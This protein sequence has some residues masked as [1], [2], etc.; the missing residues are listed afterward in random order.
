MNRESTAFAE[1]S[2]PETAS[3]G[4]TAPRRSAVAGRV[5]RGIEGGALA[6]LVMTVYRLPVTRS[7]PPSAEFWTTFVAGGR[8]G[9]HP[10][11]ALVLHF[12]Y[13]LGAGGLFAALISDRASLDRERTRS[14]LDDSVSGPPDRSDEVTATMAGLLYGVALSAV[15]ERFVLGRLLGTEPD[16]RFA[17]HVGHVLYGITLG[18]WVGTR[19]RRE[20]GK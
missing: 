20:K 3:D 19:T 17:F 10:L 13:G 15:G 4:A 16:D 14:F 6:T 18:A 2:R 11:A 9:D 1:E 5:R 12:A 8:P 7:L